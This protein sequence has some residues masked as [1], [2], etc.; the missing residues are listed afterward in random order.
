MQF[1]DYVIFDFLQYWAAV[2]AANLGIWEIFFITYMA[3]MSYYMW[4]DKII[5]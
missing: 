1:F 3:I 5:Q 2:V 4:V